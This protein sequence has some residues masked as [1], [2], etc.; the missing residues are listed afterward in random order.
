MCFVAHFIFRL[1]DVSHGSYKQTRNQHLMY[2]NE[3]ERDIDGGL[4]H[5]ITHSV[6]LEIFGRRESGLI[7]FVRLRK[8][9]QSTLV[10]CSSFKLQ[11]SSPKKVRTWNY[12]T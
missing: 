6:V 10:Q 8:L 1:L 3:V 4:F 9:A 2:G 12:K 11:I 5:L 7:G